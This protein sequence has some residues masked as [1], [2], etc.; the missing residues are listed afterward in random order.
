MRRPPPVILEVVEMQSTFVK[1]FSQVL[2][3]RETEIA[4]HHEHY[5]PAI[6]G[7]MMCA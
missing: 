1:L 4:E 7:K 5:V 3:K 6:A 2:Q